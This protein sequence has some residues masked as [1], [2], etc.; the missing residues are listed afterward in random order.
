MVKKPK[1]APTIFDRAWRRLAPLVQLDLFEDRDALA[2][3]ALADLQAFEKRLKEEKKT[4][5][6]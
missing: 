4:R 5:S 2:R 1:Q 6:A 3:I